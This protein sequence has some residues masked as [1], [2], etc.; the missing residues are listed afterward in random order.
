MF[1]VYII[2]LSAAIIY[3]LS[4]YK[5][6]YYHFFAIYRR[7]FCRVKL[8]TD[9]S[10]EWLLKPFMNIVNKKKISINIFIDKGPT[11]F[12]AS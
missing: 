10:M 11:F 4:Y 2:L 1:L 9:S 5:T 3:F 8:F 6:I 7:C 12:V